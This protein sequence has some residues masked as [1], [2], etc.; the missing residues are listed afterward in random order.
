VSLHERRPGA[1]EILL[2]LYWL[3]VLF[4]ELASRAP[5]DWLT[6]GLVRQAS[7]AGPL[8]ELYRREILIRPGE[9]LSERF[10]RLLAAGQGARQTE[11]LLEWRWSAAS[12][13]KQ[14]QAIAADLQTF[15]ERIRNDD[16]AAWLRLL[17]VAAEQLMAVN[18]LPD[19]GK[20]IAQCGAE[21]DQLGHLATR[22]PEDYDKLEILCRSVPGLVRVGKE[23]G[24]TVLWR[25]L[26]YSW[27]R[28]FDELRP[29]LEEYLA[30][31][32]QWP[33]TALLRLYQIGSFAPTLLG[34][35]TV[36]L[37]NYQDAVGAWRVPQHD[38][39][40]ATELVR[41]ILLRGADSDY[42][43]FRMML[44]DYCLAEGLLPE[45]IA[46]A[47]GPTLAEQIHKDLALQSVCWGYR[48]F[49]G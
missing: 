37:R 38:E 29:L 31:L 41:K 9:A 17:V 22:C 45:Q 49:R 44:L 23:E 1:P 19:V 40:V 7:A 6:T 34:Q 43:R 42:S 18:D 28:P 36:L 16:E 4:P 25:L 32:V 5:A 13:L 15:R 39:E 24:P 27:G 48:L 46:N 14:P 33:R 21:A 35:M 20:L 3:L 10:D 12:R 11:E 8:R 30:K 2:R 26:S 47:A